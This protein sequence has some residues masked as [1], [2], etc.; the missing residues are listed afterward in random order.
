MDHPS[1]DSFDLYHC[2]ISGGKDST[3]LALWLR[4]ESGVDLTKI[5]ITFCDTGN[6]DP[7]TYAFIGLL[8]EIIAPVPIT[9]IKPPRDY[10]ELA[11]HKGRFPS[12]KSRFCTI[13]LKILPTREDVLTL[14]R[15]GVNLLM[16][17]GVRRAE[18]HNGNERANA[19]DWDLDLGFG[20][21]LYRP[22][23]D[24]GIDQVWDIH[25][26]YIPL[27][28]V[29]DLVATDPTMKPEIRDQLIARI[30]ADGRPCN[31]LYHMGARRVGCYPCFNASKL[32][33]RSLADHRP[34]RIEFI[35]EKE[36]AVGSKNHG[37]ST[38]FRRN[39]VPARFRR[40][41]VTTKTGTYQVPTIRDV[42]DWA[43]TSY[44]GKWYATP[45]GGQLVIDF[46]ELTP[47]SACDLGGMCE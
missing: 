44:G 29:I 37:I 17:N 32:E 15:D 23:V 7:L 18:G 13:E 46:D 28:R 40:Y 30:Q 20:C 2:G 45:A 33:I 24:W 8:G 4:F 5:R 27:D 41:T 10:W 11:E 1:F 12:T 31:P 9:V 39:A 36:I 35:A 25:R 43:Q 6:E 19:P 21:W 47:A 34:E 26:K 42:A 16:L 3:A 14:L 22:I 38:F